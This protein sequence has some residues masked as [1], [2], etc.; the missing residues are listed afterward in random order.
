VFYTVPSRLIGHRLR[1]RI[2]DDRLECFL[3]MTSVATLRRGR[4]ISDSR[5]G[6]VVDL[7][8]TGTSSARLAQCDRWYALAL[9]GR[10]NIG[11]MGRAV[12][13]EHD[14]Q[15]RHALAAIRAAACARLFGSSPLLIEVA[16]HYGRAHRMDDS[17]DAGIAEIARTPLAVGGVG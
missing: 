7:S 10:L 9:S 14:R 13:A 12:I 2:F 5:S 4:P 11:R 17:G 15:T 8:T 3:G 16:G 1:D 6:H